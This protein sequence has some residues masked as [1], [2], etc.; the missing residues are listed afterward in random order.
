MAGLPGSR[1][2]EARLARQAGR[3][4]VRCRRGWQGPVVAQPV[5]LPAQEECIHTKMLMVEGVAGT[6]P[7]A[8]AAGAD[9]GKTTPL[10][11]GAD[12]SAPPRA[13]G[14]RLAMGQEAVVAGSWVGVLPAAP[15]AGMRSAP[16]AVAPRSAA[17]P[18]VPISGAPAVPIAE[19]PAARKPATAV[20]PSQESGAGLLQGPA[21]AN[22][23]GRKAA[24]TGTE[25]LASWAGRKRVRREVPYRGWEEAILQGS[26]EGQRRELAEARRK[27]LAAGVAKSL[28]LAA[29]LVEEAE[30]GRT[31]WSAPSLT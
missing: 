23:S 30:A 18:A 28:G 9:T 21:V 13:A 31:W 20:V 8:R 5:A 6:L 7:S 27:G 11:Q 1:A 26:A 10:G 25:R 19:D 15:A 12:S 24:E 4:P 16:G 29:V 22:R 14:I 17:P 2:A 3:R